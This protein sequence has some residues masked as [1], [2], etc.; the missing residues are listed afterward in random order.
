MDIRIKQIDTKRH[1]Q[2]YRFKQFLTKN[3]KIKT[4]KIDVSII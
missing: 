3:T 1:I 4:E 2:K